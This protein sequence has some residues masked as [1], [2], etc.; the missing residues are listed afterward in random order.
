MR[1]SLFLALFLACVG[2]ASAAT[3]TIG[4]GGQFADINAAMSSAAVK[5]GDV[6][7]VL[8]NTTVGDKTDQTVTKS[9]TIEGAGYNRPTTG[10]SMGN[11]VNPSVISNLYLQADGIVISKLWVKGIVYIRAND[12]TIEKCYVEATINGAQQ[13]YDTDNFTLKQ[14]EVMNLVRGL[15]DQNMQ[16]GWRIMNNIFTTTATSGVNFIQGLN[17]ALIDHNAFHII[18]TSKSSTT[19]CIK[20]VSD[21]TITN[22]IVLHFLSDGNYSA[23]FN[24][25]I[26]DKVFQNNNVT[27]NLFTGNVSYANNKGGVN[28]ANE[29]FDWTYS[30]TD[31]LWDLNFTLCANSPAKGYATDGGNCGPWDGQFPYLLGG[32][33]EVTPGPVNPPTDEFQVEANDLLALKNMYNAFGGDYWTTKKWSFANNGKSKDDFPGVTF[34]D[35]GR[36]T[37]IDLENNGLAG[38]M[39]DVYDPSFAEL[40]SLNLRR[41]SLAGD[42]SKFVAHLSKLKT[43]NMA[44][45]RIT[46]MSQALPPACS[47]V[48]LRFQNREWNND[49]ETG[50]A[51]TNNFYNLTASNITIK[52]DDSF[53][54]SLPSLFTAY[55]VNR[56]LY[57]TSNL[58]TKSG[59]LGVRN[60]DTGTILSLYG[61]YQI[62]TLEQDH[63]MVLIQEDGVT[64]HSAYPVLMHF[65]LGDADMN[66]VAN[67]YDVQYTLNYI[68]DAGSISKFNYSAA[69]TYTDNLINVQDMV[70]TVNIL[71]SQGSI[72]TARASRADAATVPSG[73]AAEGTVFSRDGLLVLNA[74][75]PVAAIDVELEG[76]ST[77]EVGL[78]LPSRDFQ[79]IG[80]NTEWGSRYIIFSLTGKSI[81]VDTETPLLRFAN[82]ALPVGIQCADT[83]AKS[84]V[85]GIGTS[86]TGI[87]S[88]I[89]DQDNADA[90]IFDL[91]GRKSLN[92]TLHKGLYIQSGKKIIFQ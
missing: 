64:R 33:E 52:I 89:A 78:M 15:D 48:D 44:Y 57:E 55:R 54:P 49:R 16:Q 47:N 1:K 12:I 35:Q 50:L 65:I 90:P 66:G 92:G 85:V 59:E 84:V 19:Y 38:E 46:E 7:Q 11:I 34:S 36:V 27:N 5:D 87:R 73:F 24:G 25:T 29:V 83:A 41:N 17:G 43:L 45:N 86:P 20:Y 82:Y 80:R 77:D 42:A 91:Q 79:M 21:C 60:Y 3:W 58:N 62:Y 69:N 13:D 2:W 72:A 63:L 8:K 61:G 70:A 4:S 76:V 74:Q 71:L 18:N 31:P 53:Y 30:S 88:R 37:A 40:T 68:L 32:V 75:R 23:T 67:V 14:C 22:N 6:L 10:V 26:M 56:G 39:F 51:L 81:A 9:V 28:S